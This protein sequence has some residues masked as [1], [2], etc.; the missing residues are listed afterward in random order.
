MSLTRGWGLGRK[1]G[2]E[3]EVGLGLGP[4]TEGGGLG[5]GPYTLGKHYLPTT[6]LGTG[7]DHHQMFLS[8]QVLHQKW[9]PP[10][11]VKNLLELVSLVIVCWI[12]FMS[13][14]IRE[15]ITNYF[16]QWRR[17]ISSAD[18]YR[19]I[20]KNNNACDKKAYWLITKVQLAGI[21]G[22]GCW[23]TWKQNWIHSRKYRLMGT[24]FVLDVW[25]EYMT[26]KGLDFTPQLF[27]TGSDDYTDQMAL[28]IDNN[29]TTCFTLT[30][31]LACSK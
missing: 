13:S 16:Y 22:N 11:A 24:L 30:K 4:C 25:Q 19:F 3:G 6:L 2:E 1:E 5:L 23:K 26:D 21:A 17:P 29:E 31:C 10:M 20:H 18:S 8:C 15:G 12:P 9:S 14:T 7:K 27:F 28:L